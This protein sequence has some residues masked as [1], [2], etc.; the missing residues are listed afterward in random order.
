MCSSDLNVAKLLLTTQALFNIG[1]FILE[2]NLIN[3]QNV[4][5]PLPPCLTVGWFL[6]HATEF[7]ELIKSNT[8]TWAQAS[9]DWHQ[10]KKNEP[11]FEFYLPNQVQT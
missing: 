1:E 5:K 4:A 6:R 8:G 11:L 3:V 7:N 2:R 9:S 10:S